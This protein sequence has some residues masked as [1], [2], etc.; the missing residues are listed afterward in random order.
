[1]NSY[2]SNSQTSMAQSGREVMLTTHPQSSAEVKERVELY[3]TLPLGLHGLFYCSEL[4][5]LPR[6]N[7][8][9]I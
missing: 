4:Y 8:D 1:M 7:E 9:K 3:F 2:I 6:V 5:L